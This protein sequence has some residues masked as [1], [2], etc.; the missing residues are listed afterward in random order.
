MHLLLYITLQKGGDFLTL[1]SISPSDLPTTDQLPP[2]S[3]HI[4]S[5]AFHPL[6]FPPRMLLNYLFSAKSCPQSN[7]GYTYPCEYSRVDINQ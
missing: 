1:Y 7:G 3:G 4:L 5:K 6:H 2:Y